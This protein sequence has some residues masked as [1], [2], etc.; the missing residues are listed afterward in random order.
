MQPEYVFQPARATGGA[1]AVLENQALNLIGRLPVRVWGLVRG[2][3]FF[4]VAYGS[5]RRSQ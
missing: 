3:Y 2:F 1:D 4:L 5:N